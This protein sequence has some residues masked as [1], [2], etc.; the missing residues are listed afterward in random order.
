MLLNIK[1]EC[2]WLAAVALGAQFIMPRKIHEKL[3]NLR[4][5]EV[6]LTFCL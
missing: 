5:P 3:I 4:C 6:L 2:F 1:F